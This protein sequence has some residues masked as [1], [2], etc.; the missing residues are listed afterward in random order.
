M[1]FS[2]HIVDFNVNLCCA[3]IGGSFGCDHV[4]PT[5]AQ[6]SGRGSP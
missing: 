5:I 2:F 6:R 4:T 3:Q 1:I